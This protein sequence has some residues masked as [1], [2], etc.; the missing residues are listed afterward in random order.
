MPLYPKVD[1]ATCASC[2]HFCRHYVRDGSR[3]F[4]LTFGHCICL[5]T[6]DRRDSS[7]CPAWTPK[8]GT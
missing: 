8:K 3:F 1:A 7:A 2:A 4:P 5:R 6:K